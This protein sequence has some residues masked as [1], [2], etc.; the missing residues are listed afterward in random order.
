MSALHFVLNFF[1]ADEVHTCCFHHRVA[2]YPVSN[3]HTTALHETEPKEK[4][5]LILVNYIKENSFSF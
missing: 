3:Y 1:G 4:K 5:Q 2:L